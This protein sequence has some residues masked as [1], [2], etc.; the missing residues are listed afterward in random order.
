M[1]VDHVVP[2]TNGGSD[3]WDNLVCAC[4]KCNNRKGDSTPDKAGMTLQHRPTRPIHI[5]FIQ[6]YVGVQDDHWRQYLFMD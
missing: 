6:R 1:T 5:T 3:S 4:V 2:K